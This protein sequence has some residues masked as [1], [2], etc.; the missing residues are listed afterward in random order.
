MTLYLVYIYIPFLL[1]TRLPWMERFFAVGKILK[2]F[3]IS[4][5]NVLNNFPFYYNV[6]S[7][8]ISYKYWW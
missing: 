3:E 6:F 7:A 5:T 4:I 8:L 2:T 1:Y